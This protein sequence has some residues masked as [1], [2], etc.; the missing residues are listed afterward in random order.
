MVKCRFFVFADSVYLI[1]F[2]LEVNDFNVQIL[3]NNMFLWSIFRFILFFIF[4]LYLD[5]VI[6]GIFALFYFSYFYCVLMV[7]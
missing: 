4:L 1:G 2:C 5:G 7:L 6:V 3:K